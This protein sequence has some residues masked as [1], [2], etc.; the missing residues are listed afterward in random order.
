MLFALP[1]PFALSRAI[2]LKIR[3]DLQWPTRK[4][5]VHCLQL[6]LFAEVMLIELDIPYAKEIEIRRAN[7]LIAA[8]DA[9]VQKPVCKTLR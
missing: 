6:M 8:V 2:S 5:L 7:C 4:Q 3:L 1:C 9:L